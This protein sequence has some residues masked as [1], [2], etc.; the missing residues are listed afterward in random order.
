MKETKDKARYDVGYGK[1]PKSWQ[2]KK[3]QSGNPKGRPKIERNLLNLVSD[4]LENDLQTDNRLISGHEALHRATIKAALNG[5]QRA[6]KRFVRLA[7][8][9]GM[10]KDIGD[11]HK[12]LSGVVHFPYIKPDV[13][14]ES[15]RLRALI[16][17]V[18]TELAE[19]EVKLAERQ[20]R[21]K[22]KDSVK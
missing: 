14:K 6:F 10:F 22:D 8:Q 5:N 15:A 18:D 2:F 19:L 16:K 11:R 12:P 21:P 1:P 13:E 17:E 20:N 3:G 4:L 9:S 7:K